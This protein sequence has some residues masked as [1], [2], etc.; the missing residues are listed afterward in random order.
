MMSSHPAI[1]KKTV[2][3]NC[4]SHRHSYPRPQLYMPALVLG[5]PRGDSQAAR[6]ISCVVILGGLAILRGL[7][8]ATIDL[9]AGEA[10]YWTWSKERVIP[11][12]DPPPLI[13]WCIRATTQLFGDTNF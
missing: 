7:Y 3:R 9:T 11:Y 12:P 8:S 4:I 1:F 6:L 5:L 13:A 2:S 10:Y